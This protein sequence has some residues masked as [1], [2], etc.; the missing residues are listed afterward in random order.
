MCSGITVRVEE[1][2]EKK[3]VKAKH[4]KLYSKTCRIHLSNSK[5]SLSLH[6]HEQSFQESYLQTFSCLKSPTKK[7]A[8][9][10]YE[11]L[12]ASVS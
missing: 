2:E 7:I 3:E 1:E 4:F 11:N 9:I 6:H 12:D 5:K 10:S 8:S